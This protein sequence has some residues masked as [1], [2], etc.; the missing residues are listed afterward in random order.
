VDGVILGCSELPFLVEP[1]VA[2]AD[3]INP[4]ELLAEAAVAL[5]IRPASSA[6]FGK[7]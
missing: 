1:T 2:E 6:G 3:L 5:A 7:R 4:I